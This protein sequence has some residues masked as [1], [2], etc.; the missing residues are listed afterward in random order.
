MSVPAFILN[1]Q[2]VSDP[3]DD[4]LFDMI[5]DYVSPDGQ[6]VISEYLTTDKT[7]SEM[8]RRIKMIG[9]ELILA[10]TTET[11]ARLGGMAWSNA[12]KLTGKMVEDMSKTEAGIYFKKILD[13]QREKIKC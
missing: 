13:S 10:G 9:Q 7:N 11:A 1:D 12:K 2:I 3:F 5:E 6:K 8:E 4:N